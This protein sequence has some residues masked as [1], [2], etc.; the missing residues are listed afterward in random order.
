MGEASR[1]VTVCS[2]S[3]ACPGKPGEGAHACMPSLQSGVRLFGTLW[4]VPARLL[5]PWDSQASMLE[6]VAISASRGSSG[7]RDEI[8]VSSVSC[9]G[10][11]F[12]RGKAVGKSCLSGE[13]EEETGRG[14]A[15]ATYC[16]SRD[17]A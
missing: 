5:C 12:F 8:C 7:P 14:Q 11:R 16:L 10:S 2:Q 1:L 6:R 9:I 3:I 17:P 13:E 15:R 4:T